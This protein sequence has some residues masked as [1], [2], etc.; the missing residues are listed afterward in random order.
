MSLRQWTKIR[1]CAPCGRERTAEAPTGRGGCCRSSRN[2]PSPHPGLAPWATSAQEPGDLCEQIS[3]EESGKR[4][5]RGSFARRESQGE[6]RDGRCFEACDP[7]NGEQGQTVATVYAFVPVMR[8]EANIDDARLAFCFEL[9]IEKRV[10]SL[11]YAGRNGLALSV[12]GRLGE[13]RRA[14][15]ER[16]EG[17]EV[18]RRLVFLRLN[19]RQR[20]ERL[21]AVVPRRARRNNT[22]A[23]LQGAANIVSRGPTPE[24]R[25]LRTASASLRRV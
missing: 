13:F 23:L 11:G 3:L 4:V 5:R 12:Q 16:Y 20:R 7:I 2:V 6:P 24:P 18:E 8:S 19:S 22:V 14:G 15:L 21:D 17:S 1:D 9:S 10:D 25:R